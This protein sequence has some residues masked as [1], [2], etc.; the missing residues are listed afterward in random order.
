MKR[1]NLEEESKV[2]GN[3]YRD[4]IRAYG[5]DCTYYKLDTKCFDNFNNIID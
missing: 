4:L 5:L 2:V 3:W 1:D